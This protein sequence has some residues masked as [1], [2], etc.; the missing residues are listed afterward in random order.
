VILTVEKKKTRRLAKLGKERSD[1]ARQPGIVFAK[2]NSGHRAGK[3][4]RVLPL[5]FL[6]CQMKPPA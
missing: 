4:E 2:K 5:S 1:T 6:A 3:E